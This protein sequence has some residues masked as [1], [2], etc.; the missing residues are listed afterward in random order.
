MELL[1]AIRQRRAVREFT[2][3]RVDRSTVQNLI[4]AAILAPSAMNLQPWAFAVL[5]DPERIDRYSTVAKAW[6]VEHFSESS[7]DPSLRKV[8]EDPKRELFSRPR[9]GAGAGHLF[10]RSGAGG[11]LLGCGKLHAGSPCT[12]TR[13]LLD[14]PRAAMAE[15][16]DGQGRTGN[17]RRPYGGCAHRRW[18]SEGMAAIPRSEPS[19]HPLA[20]LTPFIY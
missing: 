16:H 18:L 14:R 17:S 10:G 8:I 3:S 19:D 6:L 7:L 12:G 15:P 2:A 11:L 20:R 4:D 1:E 5:L 9:S 13:N